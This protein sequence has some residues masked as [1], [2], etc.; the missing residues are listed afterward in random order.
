MKIRI[1]GWTTGFLLLKMVKVLFE[2]ADMGLVE[3]KNRCDHLLSENQAFTVE[4][5]DESLVKEFIKEIDQLNVL[6]QIIDNDPR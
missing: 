5:I 1:T 6:Y 4:I 3:A 2:Y